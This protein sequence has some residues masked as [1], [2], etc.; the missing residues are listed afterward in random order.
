M[1]VGGHEHAHAREHAHECEVLD[2]LVAATVGTD[3]DAR[4][5]GRELHVEVAVA[6]GVADLVVGAAGGEHGEGSRERHLARGGEA[7]G[8]VDHVRLGDADVE[9]ALGVGV[10]QL[11]GGGGL[12][13]VGLDRDDVDAFVREFDERLAQGLAGRLLRH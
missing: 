3:G 10:L 6:H 9:E 1:V 13:E 4:V 2:H 5:G 11:R 8:N 12:G 7:G